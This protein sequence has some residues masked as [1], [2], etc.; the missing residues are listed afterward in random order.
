MNRKELLVVAMLLSFAW[1]G[2]I[3][4]CSKPSSAKLQAKANEVDSLVIKGR[5]AGIRNID[6]LRTAQHNLANQYSSAIDLELLVEKDQFDAARLFKA[7]GKLDTTI[8]LLEKYTAERDSLPALSL[9]FDSYVDRGRTIA[10]EDLFFMRLKSN[11]AIRMESYLLNLFWTY[12]EVG[13]PL[14]AMAIADSAIRMLPP[15]DAVQFSVDKAELLWSAG[16][17]QEALSML[18]E[19]RNRYKDDPKTMRGITAKWNLLGLIDKPAPELKTK[20]WVGAKPFRLADVRGRVVLLDFWAPWCGPCRAMFPHLKQLYQ[21]Y[22]EKG[23]EIIGVTRYYGYFNQLGQNLKDIPQETER[24]WISLFKQKHEIPFPYAIGE[25]ESARTN[26]EVFGE[27][28]IPHMLLLDKKGR[29]RVFAVGS[30]KA[31]E[32]KLSKGVVE[33]LGE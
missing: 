26:S 15:E 30:G 14:K 28:G 20:D 12:Q 2:L 29:V 9:L 19:L 11:Q 17:K 1:A 18:G 31:S 21:A 13:M 16:Q 4:S 27:Y 23:L 8:L 6:S 22:H 32:E 3:I 10:A 24:Q 25:G 5:K 33:L 7:A